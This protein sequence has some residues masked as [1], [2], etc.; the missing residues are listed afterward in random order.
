M[1]RMIGAVPQPLESVRLI[2]SENRD[3]IDGY[4]HGPRFFLPFT[5]ELLSRKSLL[6]PFDDEDRI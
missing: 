5:P 4:G 3:G 1:V 2:G 6:S